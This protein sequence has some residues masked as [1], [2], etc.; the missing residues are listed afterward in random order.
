MTPMKNPRTSLAAAA[1][2][3]VA[4][5]LAGCSGDAPPPP[6]RDVTASVLVAESAAVPGRSLTLGWRFELADEW[7]LYADLRNDSGLPPSVELDLPEGWTAGPLRWP[8]AARHAAPGGILDHV[9]EGELVLMQSVTVAPDAPFGETVSF[10]ATLRWLA[11]R[12]ACVPG[13]TTLTVTVPVGA[14]AEPT[15]DSTP[16]T[17]VLRRL[18]RPADSAGVIAAWDGDVLKVSAPDAVG[19]EFHPA[20][21]CGELSDAL[22]DAA[23]DD[24]DLALRFRPRDDAVGPARG[25]LRIALRN[26][27]VRFVTL[28]VPASPHQGDRS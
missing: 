24:P 13:D 4:A 12:E 6:P 8:G 11:C 16:L 20:V 22:S 2:L 10:D 9:Y 3:V 27:A 18:P 7:H 23:S 17:N 21:D 15:A 26:G 25:V 14:H 19:L 28:D 5:A 1:L